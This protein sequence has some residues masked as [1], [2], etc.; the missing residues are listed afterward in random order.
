MLNL[1]TV[2]RAARLRKSADALR[3]AVERSAKRERRMQ[4]PRDSERKCIRACSCRWACCGSPCGEDGLEFPDARGARH[5]QSRG[6]HFK[7]HGATYH[8]LFS[9]AR[10]ERG[11]HALAPRANFI[12]NYSRRAVRGKSTCLQS[13]RLIPPFSK[14]AWRDSR[15]SQRA[16]RKGARGERC[17]FPRNEARGAREASVW[18]LRV[19]WASN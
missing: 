10:G 1:N 17:A 12:P 4:T 18:D 5:E 13:A 16:P 3:G 8:L 9:N 6:S 14:C 15:A 2:Q 19:R 11:E 7:Y